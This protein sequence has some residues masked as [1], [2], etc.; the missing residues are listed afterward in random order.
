[1]DREYRPK[2]IL[3]RKVVKGQ[4]HIIQKMFCPKCNRPVTY[5]NKTCKCGLKININSRLEWGEL[6]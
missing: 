5:T 4:M 1:M 3:E 2:L 6:A